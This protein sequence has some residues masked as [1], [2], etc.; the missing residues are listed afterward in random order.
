MTTRWN[1]PCD[2]T[3]EEEKLCKMMKTTGKLFV[4]LR[5]QRHE[6]FDEAFQEQLEKVHSGNPRGTEPKPAALLTMVIFL[7]AYT[8][9]SDDEAVRRAAMDKAWQMVLG[10]LGAENAPFSKETLG[11]FRGRLIELQLDKVLI[12]RSVELA[13]ASR[14][15]DPKK[16]SK[17]RVAIDSC[18]LKGAGRVEDTIN[19]LGTALWGLITTVSFLLCLSPEQIISQAQLRLL[20]A[21]SIKAGLDLDWARPDAAHR[22]LLEVIAEV[23]RLNSWISVHAPML[24]LEDGQKIRARVQMLRIILQN[25]DLD[26]DGEPVMKEG[27][28]KDRQISY[29]DPAM[30]HGRKTSSVKINGYKRYEASDLDTDVVLDACVLPANVPEADGA[31]K[32]A[33]TLATYGGIKELAIDRA[34]LTSDL[35]EQVRRDPDAVVVCRAPSS[36]NGD[37]FSKAEFQIDL[38][39]NKVSCPAGQTTAIKRNVASFPVELCSNCPQRAKCQPEGV[40][41]GRQ[42]T[43]HR[44]EPLVQELL[45]Q[46]RTPEG[47]KKLRERTA[48]E[49]KLAH[50]AQRQ[51]PRAR[52]IG[53]AKN[54]FDA[55][56]TG[57]IDNLFAALRFAS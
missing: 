11:R 5:R 57:A 16:L 17:L 29:W 30:R 14:G 10:C 2:L 25:I 34:F 23:D 37:L 3:A 27:T 48:I 7:Q 21:P 45:K 28:V 51:G 39:E 24:A 44:D 8:G 56:R 41:R 38:V 4:F 6:L 12:A 52:Y 32:M 1:P 47:R 49:H 15:F 40:R 20:S 42:I 26:A 55:R 31:D 50:M 19:L 46:Q 22:G 43:L 18:P 9:A 36:S 35:C 33:P 54:D 53:I 13:R